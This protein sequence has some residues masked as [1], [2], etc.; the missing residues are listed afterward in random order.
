MQAASERNWHSYPPLNIIDLP[1]LQPRCRFWWDSNTSCRIGQGSRG[2]PYCLFQSPVRLYPVVFLKIYCS[3]LS[4]L[5][6]IYACIDMCMSVCMCVA[7][8]TWTWN[9]T[10]R[11]VEEIESQKK[12]IEKTGKWNKCS[13]QVNRKTL[14]CL[15]RGT[16]RREHGKGS[17]PERI[18][19]ILHT[20]TIYINQTTHE[21]Y[22]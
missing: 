9:R 17:A 4:Y 11:E 13:M 3:R 5:K 22:S 8:S 10:M 20:Y 18:K 2:E 21:Y 16:V 7:C 15:W 12:K 19:R 1:K 14:V 6:F